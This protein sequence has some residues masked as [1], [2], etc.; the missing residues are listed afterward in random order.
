MNDQLKQKSGITPEKVKQRD[1][2]AFVVGVTNMWV[3]ALLVG[4]WPEVLPWFYVA[5]IFV[6]LCLRLVVYRRKRW[7]Y[8]MF[9]M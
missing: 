8:F 4:V 7:H 1:K 9:D 3:T 5:K 6:L 2:L